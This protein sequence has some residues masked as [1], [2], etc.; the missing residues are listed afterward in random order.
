MLTVE[1]YVAFD[2]NFHVFIEHAP[3]VYSVD[4]TNM[5]I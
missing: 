5:G 1:K 3:L 2:Y 4:I